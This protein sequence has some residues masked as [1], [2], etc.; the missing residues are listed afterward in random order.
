MLVGQPRTPI[1]RGKGNSLESS[2]NSQLDDSFR[3]VLESAKLQRRR[4][5]VE[6]RL[7]RASGI[8]SPARK[9]GSGN[10]TP[11]RARLSDDEVRRSF[12]EW[13][14]I[15]ADNKINASNSWNLALIDYFHDMTL[16]RDGD[17]IN[18]Q[19]ASCTL[20]GCV[21][22]YT[23][24]VDS[25]DSETKKLLSGL[26]DTDKSMRVE[27][28]NLSRS[29]ATNPL[30]L[31]LFSGP[32]DDDL[33]S[34][35]DDDQINAKPS[36][37]RANRSGNTLERDMNNLNVKK[38]DLEFM[39]DPL[40][41]KT[42][43]DFDEGGAHGLLLNHLSISPEGRMVFDAGDADMASR[44][45]APETL[46]EDPA[47][48]CIDIV[49]LKAR[50]LDNLTDIWDQDVCST[51]KGFEFTSS[52][53]SWTPFPENSAFDFDF[54][55]PDDEAD[56]SSPFDDERSQSIY[57]NYEERESFDGVTE[58]ERRV[59][60]SGPLSGAAIL[61]T[62][63][64]ADDNIFSY[65]DT[66]MSRSWAG[67]EH[68]RA[69]PA[70]RIK[71]SKD[72]PAT[73]RKRKNENVLNFIEVQ[74]MGEDRLFAPTAASIILPKQTERNRSTHLLPDDMHF[75]SKDFLQLFL[76]SRYKIK[77]YRK[78]GT[79]TKSSSQDGPVDELFWAEHDIEPK[80]SST[81]D[82][83]LASD[84]PE[85]SDDDDADDD[86]LDEDVSLTQADQ[87]TTLEFRDQLVDQPKKV[88]AVP[89]NYARVAKKVDVKKLKENI[90]KELT[91]HQPSVQVQSN[92][93]H[94][95]EATSFTDIVR[96]LDDFYPEK[97]RKDISVAFCFICVLHLAN[98]QNLKVVGNSDLCNLLISQEPEHG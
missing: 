82:Q 56:E 65:F 17:S 30:T 79:T 54:S 28:Q 39:V 21:K 18:F 13:M 1:R 96:G 48:E 98:E 90:W 73:K 38:F 36:K 92:S 89:L 86:E 12:E 46:N 52:T 59:S 7:R 74:G 70:Q 8:L 69:L 77:F 87:A 45:A 35:E 88:K 60:A 83:I 44:V 16:L 95:T 15:A 61:M 41:K 80:A 71:D 47:R 24:R 64:R 27:W 40:F 67:P 91:L 78:D 93:L 3:K 2:P 63:G 6:D 84:N 62:M 97:K 66:A 9:P 34:G 33:E 10:V 37:K 29:S 85:G 11:A 31:K 53:G 58:Q 72:P 94:V 42:S 26:V 49:K 5:V 43:A 25:V 32:D 81:D 50:F 14:K 55:T 76:K 68:W 75:S 19:K 57:G 51:L 20:D 22:I 4:S 23:S